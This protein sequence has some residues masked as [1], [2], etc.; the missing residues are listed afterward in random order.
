M[1][2]EIIADRSRTGKANSSERASD[3][4]PLLFVTLYICHFR[5]DRLASQRSGQDHMAFDYIGYARLSSVDK[6]SELTGFSW[7]AI[8]RTGR[9]FCW[10]SRD[11][12]MKEKRNS[13]L[14]Y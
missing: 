2:F 5:S 9:A 12:M 11:L 14:Q 3:C 13:K 8:N 1:R 4:F 10:S 7:I 6:K